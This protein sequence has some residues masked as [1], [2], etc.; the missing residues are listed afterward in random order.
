M[1]S[2]LVAVALIVSFVGLVLMIW[3]LLRLRKLHLVDKLR[4]YRSE[5]PGFADLLSYASMIADGIIV[6]KNGALSAAWRYR[7]PDAAS[8]SD[9][10]YESLCGHLNQALKPLGAGWML[11]IDAFRNTSEPGE[12]SAHFGDR[13]T[14]AIDRERQ[15]A[16]AQHGTLFETEYVLTVTWYPPLLVERKFIGFFFDDGQLLPDQKERTTDVLQAFDRSIRQLESRLSPIFELKRLRAEAL[17]VR[18]KTVVYDRFLQHLHRCITGVDHPVQLPSTPIYLDALLGVRELWTGL[19]P[20]LGDNY[21]QVIAIEGFPPQSTPGILQVLTELPCVYRWSTRFIPLDEH[22]ALAH[23]QKFRRKWRQQVRGFMDQLLNLGSGPVNQDAVQMLAEAEEAMGQVH[24]G[25][26]SYGYY[27]SVVVLQG[28][29][30]SELEQLALYVSKQINRLGFVTRI[31]SVNTLEAYLGSLPGEGHANVRRPLIHTVNLAD[32]LPTSSLWTGSATAPCPL[33]PPQSPPLM[34]VVAEGSTPFWLNLHVQDV[35]HTFMF[36]PTGS[37][38]STHLAMLAAQLRRYPGM[39]IYCF[40][41]GGSMYTLA[42]G[43]RAVTNGRTGRYFDVAGDR[44]SLAFCPLQFHDKAWALE[45]L[46]TLLGLNGVSVPPARRN[47][48]ARALQS[49]YD[50]GGCTLSDLVTMVQDETVREALLVYTIDGPMGHLLD[51]TEDGLHISDFTVFEIENLLQLG[52][53]YA[54]PV[55][56]YLFRRI[57]RS[58]RGQPA[59]IILDE[60]WVM[61]GHE[62]FREKVREWLKVLRKENC[63]VLMATQ[64]LSDA[65]RSGIF[66]VIIESCP[67]KIFL[68]NPHALDDDAAEIYRRM[69]LNRPQICTIAEA[70]PKQ[71][72]YYASPLGRR[73]YQLSLGPLALAMTASSDKESMAQIQTLEQTMGPSWLPF[74][75]QKRGLKEML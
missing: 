33:Y 6:H 38:K 27:T 24:S 9:V 67:T 4:S 43:I 50:S 26:V 54:L 14:A 62:V 37:G 71:D 59:A 66:D 25:Y 68:P 63:L 34:Q 12:R 42:A 45:W 3:L 40:D 64:S 1:V 51:A 74:W 22:Q 18:S 23:F 49:M 53:R 19:T 52:D 72:Y 47:A 28:R 39:S 30:I 55:L 7:A 32:L 16:F 35:G 48:L 58:L 5:G 13:L 8:L 11:H 10:E 21:V 57:Q 65:L 31:E 29:N 73:L 61:L 20:R 70:K 36:G 17:V 15:R 2:T 44:S 60:A 46:E 69:G 75:L 56:L 41:K